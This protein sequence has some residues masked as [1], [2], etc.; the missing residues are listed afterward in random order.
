MGNSSET[1]LKK[2]EAKT[3]TKNSTNNDTSRLELKGWQQHRNQKYNL[4][5]Q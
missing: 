1:D 2:N 4:W 3:E 5:F